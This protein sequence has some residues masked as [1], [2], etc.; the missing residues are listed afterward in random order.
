LAGLLALLA[1]LVLLTFLALLTLLA[2]LLVLLLLLLVLILL[3]HDGLLESLQTKVPAGAL[4]ALKDGQLVSNG[5]RLGRRERRGVEKP[6]LG[7]LAG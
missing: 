1:A 2:V 4:K 3:S 6:A 7:G 5:L